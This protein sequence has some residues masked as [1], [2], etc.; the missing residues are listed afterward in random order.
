MASNQ[1]VFRMKF[2]EVFRPRSGAVAFFMSILV[3]GVGIGCFAATMNNFLA[4][5]YLMNSV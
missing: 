4:D 5:M 1:G 2:T 3:W